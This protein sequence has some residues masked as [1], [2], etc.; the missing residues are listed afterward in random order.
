MFK[1]ANNGDLKPL[2]KFYRT[3]KI[4]PK[5]PAPLSL[6]SGDVASNPQKVA[7][8]WRN[9]FAN[10]FDHRIRQ[11]PFEMLEKVLCTICS[12][13]QICGVGGESTC[14]TAVQ[15]EPQCVDWV[16]ELSQVAVTM[17]AGKAIGVD[18]IP[19]KLVVWLEERIGVS[20][21]RL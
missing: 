2:C 18:S 11:V 15:M 16:D 13:V 17:R 3:T 4:G 20:W 14:V 19:R 1:A 21:L 12:Q 5:V 8:V 9:H 10:H 6:P 7:D